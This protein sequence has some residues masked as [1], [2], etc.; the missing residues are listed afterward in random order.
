[1]I[2]PYV[3]YVTYTGI[4][5]RVYRWLP[6]CIQ[7]NPLESST[8][9]GS[10]HCSIERFHVWNAG[11]IFRCTKLSCSIRA[12]TLVSKCQQCAAFAPFSCPFGVITAVELCTACLLRSRWAQKR[13][14]LR[15][16]TDLRRKFQPVS[17]CL[18]KGAENE[19]IVV[20]AKPYWLSAIRQALCKLLGRQGVRFWISHWRSMASPNASP[21]TLFVSSMFGSKGSFLASPAST[22]AYLAHRPG[23]SAHPIHPIHPIHPLPHYTFFIIII[24][25]IIISISISISITIIIIIIIFI[26]YIHIF[27][28][29]HPSPSGMNISM[30][31]KW[32]VRH[33]WSGESPTRQVLLSP[34]KSNHSFLLI[35]SKRSAI[36]PTQKRENSL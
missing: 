15:S 7:Y 9:R 34:I 16:F 35:N 4:Y 11:E 8:N 24:I 31:A 19:Q 25:I 26:Y 27:I 13:Q 33:T 10:E 36:L 2:I 32:S 6:K 21:S 3:S 22:T 12:C 29:I 30:T 23:S 20:N 14:E 28:I 5:W 18:W 1:M 17:Q